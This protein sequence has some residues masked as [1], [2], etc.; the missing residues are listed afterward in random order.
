M[1]DITDMAD[2]VITID[3]G[4]L[5]ADFHR[6]ITAGDN[7][8]H[9]LSS[10]A[11]PFRPQNILDGFFS[12]VDN[13]EVAPPYST[14]TVDTPVTIQPVNEPP[15]TAEDIFAETEGSEIQ[16]PTLPPNHFPIE[17]S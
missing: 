2:R 4:A 9:S 6:V 8:I 1:H 12:Q 7:L 3:T 16:T 13:P 17:L 15:V 14:G 11:T 10:P 5:T